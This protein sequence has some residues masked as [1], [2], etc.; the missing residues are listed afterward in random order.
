[1]KC[2]PWHGTISSAKKSPGKYVLKSGN[3]LNKKSQLN[4]THGWGWGKA[5]WDAGMKAGLV[6]KLVNSVL[7]LPY[8][9]RSNYWLDIKNNNGI[10]ILR[11]LIM[12]MHVWKI[13]QLYCTKRFHNVLLKVIKFY[14]FN[15]STR[16]RGGWRDSF[17]RTG[18]GEG[19]PE[20]QWLIHCL[21]N[22]PKASQIL[23]VLLLIHSI[24]WAF[25][26]I[27]KRTGT[28]PWRITKMPWI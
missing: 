1:M 4:K 26:S 28:H 2:L 9:L 13:Y 18:F 22:F 17:W 15:K 24:M 20:S 27:T 21:S 25:S 11:C 7:K 5:I 16:N 6:C 23:F 19:E 8:Q 14:T 12:E 3:L 10:C